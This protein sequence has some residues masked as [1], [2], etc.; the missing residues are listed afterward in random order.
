[1]G[2]GRARVLA[3]DRVTARSASGVRALRRVATGAA[4]LLVCSL[5]G[6]AAAQ[7]DPGLAQQRF[8]EGLSHYRAR[9]YDDALRAFRASYELAPSPNSRLFIGRSLRELG[10]LGRAYGELR[11]AASEAEQRGRT[12]PRYEPTAEAADTEAGELEPRIGRVTVTMDDP[13]AGLRVTVAGR[14]FTDAGLGLAVPVDPGEITIAAEAEGREPVRMTRRLRAA[15]EV[16]L[17]LRME[18]IADGAGA[19]ALPPVVAP[20][21]SRDGPPVGD[22]AS[23]LAVGGWIA[24]G[25]GAAAAV[26]FAVFYAL[27]DARFED[28]SGECLPS[29]CPPDRR[30]DIDEGRAFQTY[31]NVSLGVSVAS[32]ALGVSL[33]LAAHLGGGS[34]S[35]AAAAADEAPA[36]VR[37]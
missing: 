14:E 5:A 7:T 8:E 22:G 28:L 21:P 3:L 20:D 30:A 13:P 10:E 26:S 27:A 4:V 36:V 37:W 17:A 11:L 29:A 16:S 33:L 25:L 32:L 35:P 24:T 34:G 19:G 31:A 15:E 6:A 2:H 18:R 23:P 1:M 12:D 9:R